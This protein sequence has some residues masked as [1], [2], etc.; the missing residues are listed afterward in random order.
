MPLRDWGPPPTPD[1]PGTRLW[2]EC[3]RAADSGY[4]RNPWV[5]WG[6]KHRS[7][8]IRARQQ[9]SFRCIRREAVAE[10][11]EGGE[12][13]WSGR[14]GSQNRSVTVAKVDQ[15]WANGPFEYL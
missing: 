13:A 12:L 6:G 15:M 2:S 1:G 8:R 4:P 7:T 14:P 11:H 3:A 5:S 10:V 9:G